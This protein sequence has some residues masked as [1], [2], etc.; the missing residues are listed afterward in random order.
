[1]DLKTPTPL[2]D[3]KEGE[4]SITEKILEI[5]AQKKS[6]SK[7][8]LS[9]FTLK[10][11]GE[12]INPTSIHKKQEKKKEEK[13]SVYSNLIIKEKISLYIRNNKEKII[14]IS[15]VAVPFLIL[16][17]LIIVIFSYTKSEPY[18]LASE[19][20][21]NIQERDYKRAYELTTETFK[22]VNEFEDFKEDSEK[23]NT[24]DISNPRVI[25]KRLEK[26][27][28]MGEY[29]HIKY[30]ISGYYVNITVFNDDTKWGIHSIEIS[31]EK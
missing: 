19:F 16:L 18:R 5:D 10:K 12:K 25:N 17:I 24:V 6:G 31:N 29:A 4:K 27:E 20:L 1:M 21:T 11:R 15:I 3:K 13:I 7:L 22:T 9:K 28:G 23:L 26:P 2:G 8:D 14:N 30:R